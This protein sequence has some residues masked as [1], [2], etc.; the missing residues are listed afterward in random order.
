MSAKTVA[1][2][3]FFAKTAVYTLQPLFFSSSSVFHCRDE[4]FFLFA[5][6]LVL[7][8]ELQRPIDIVVSIA[9]HEADA[10]A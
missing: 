6:Y 7:I 4:L 1:S 10:G 5:L 3:I 8:S 2:H 9:A